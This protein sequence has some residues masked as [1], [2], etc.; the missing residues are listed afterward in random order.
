MTP[1]VATQ[2]P[3]PPPPPD[4]KNHGQARKDEVHNRNEARKAEK[5]ADKAEKQADKAQA[6]ADHAHAKAEKTEAKA[7]KAEAKGDFK[8]AEQ[9][10]AKAE[11]QEALDRTMLFLANCE[12]HGLSEQLKDEAVRLRITYRLKTPDAII[13]ATAR[14]K[15]IPFITGDKGL[16]RLT[17]ELDLIFVQYP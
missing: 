8:K 12:R 14:I 7:E 5:N 16:R 10:E 1:A 3:P 2:P 17:E 13:A 6:K 4:H 9:L 15:R 11:K